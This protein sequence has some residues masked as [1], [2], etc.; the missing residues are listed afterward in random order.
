M[1]NHGFLRVGAASP[2][3]KVSDT[4]YNT[5]EILK[6]I[7]SAKENGCSI[8]VFPELAI[9]G[10]TC[11][12]LFWH[13][14]L[15]RGALDGLK[16]ILEASRDR[17]MLIVVGL[18]LQA[19]Q[20]LYNCAA[21]ILNG[22]ILGIVPKTYVTSHNEFQETRWFAS[23]VEA[24]IS[25]MN[26]FD[27]TVPFGSVLFQCVNEGMFF[28][29]G[30][31]IGEDLLAAIPPSS[32]LASAG[33]TVIA[34]LS[35]SEEGVEG[36]FR[37]K[38]LVTQQSRRCIVGYVYASAG[39]HES[40]T[41]SVFS[42]DCIIAENGRLLERNDLFLRDSSL[43]ITELDLQRLSTERLKKR[44]LFTKCCDEVNIQTVQFAYRA[45][46]D[47]TSLR[48]KFEQHPF[49]P[50]ALVRLEEVCNEVMNMQVAG[51]A[52]RLEHIGCKHVTIGVS[53][54]LDSTLALLVVVNAFDL[55][56]IDRRGILAV[57]M[58]GFATTKETLDNSIG[59][60]K[61]LG[62]TLK[63]INIEAAC[64]Q[65]FED[66][67]HDINVYD[68]TY[69]N[70]QARERTQILMDL[71][72]K[73]GG[74]VIGTGDLSEL[75][76]GWTTYNGD[77]M[78]MYAVNSSVPKTLIRPMLR[79]AAKG[80]FADIGDILLRIIDTPISPELIPGESG[81]EIS[82]RTE[83]IIGPYE[84][85]D[86]FLYY[87]VRYSMSPAKILFLAE[88]AFEGR[89]TSSEIK[90]W[91]TVFCRRFFT[92]QFKRSCLPDGPKVGSV[93]LSPRGSWR[94]PS[95]ADFR[96]WMDEFV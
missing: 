79:W 90:K 20:S 69:E 29:V 51:L 61:S 43:I 35:A 10:Y 39:V 23:G 57:T 14:V 15:L 60:I 38:Q 86:F 85:H 47:M 74:I 72:N 19:G 44:G 91:L 81:K 3:L 37:R 4:V 27:Q 64:M 55:L 49:V 18:P 92:Q 25:S 70:V 17:D 12:D 40:T 59:L 2:K 50:E 80:K 6:L 83:D 53:G 46:P 48:R 24:D 5:A 94:M 54:G 28:S 95:D 77:H 78:S 30:I 66:I 71:A 84:L 34:N 41:D 16:A 26:I 75:A 9:T 33:A 89:Y 32:Y 88:Q 58:P 21:V 62:A 82:Q 42:G 13:N 11:G 68:T 22:R 36:A 76:L 87:F 7:D 56:G 52:K 93:S 73:M 45:L 1:H 8:L 67:G 63:E 31:E 65:H 96:I